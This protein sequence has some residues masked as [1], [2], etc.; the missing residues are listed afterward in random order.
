[1]S[2]LKQTKDQFIKLLNG[3]AFVPQGL[4]ELQRYFR[5]N[6]PINFEFKKSDDGSIVAI[7]T[8]FRYGSIIATGK[9]KEEIDL[10]IKDAI[11]TSFEIPSSYAKEA[12]IKNEG[13][14]KVA[15]AAI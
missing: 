12:G 2:V 10:N 15:Y 3:K 13:E 14:S 7:S 1:M 8:N 4:V 11:L 6:S 5:T 9:N